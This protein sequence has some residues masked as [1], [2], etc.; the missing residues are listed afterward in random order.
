MLSLRQ[1]GSK[2]VYYLRGTVTVG[3]R[4]IDVK[5]HTTGCR[6]LDAAN[7]FKA[8]LEVELQ[9]ELIYGVSPTALSVTFAE[10]ALAYLQQP[11]K[12]INRLDAWRI[13]EISEVIGDVAIRDIEA[14]WEAMFLGS[15]RCKDLALAT[16]ERFRAMAQAV[17]SHHCKKKKVP[18]IKLETIKFKNK[19]V[20][21]LKKAVRERLIAEYPKHVQPIVLVLAFQGAR[22]QEALQLQWSDI[23]FD[24][25][26]ICFNRTKNGE[27]RTVWM[28]ERV[29]KVLKELWEKRGKPEEGHVFLNRVGK[30]YADTRDYKFPG[31]NPLKNSHRGACERARVKNFTV[32]DW[33]HVWASQC[34]M[35]GIDIKT[36]QRLGGW[37]DFRM[38]QRYADVHDEHVKA[39]V[40]KLT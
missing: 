16:L 8:R 4:C 36:V 18:I 20:R 33:R 35:D 2:K 3:D 37:K 34:L 29:E 9:N 10:A 7:A 17:I 24:Q 21:T 28:H 22:T 6:D 32:H 19:R 40:N 27:S 12:K 39:S 25:K 11:K 14:A 38:L 23:D 5:E 31:G 15:D 30:P 1:R 26:S 13:A